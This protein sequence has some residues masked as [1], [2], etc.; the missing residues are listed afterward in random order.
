MELSEFEREMY[1]NAISSMKFIQEQINLSELNVLRD[2][3]VL[4]RVKKQMKE[5]RETERELIEKYSDSPI[6][7]IINAELDER[8]K[9]NEL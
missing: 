6:M 3:V 5:Y 8:V 4:E 2:D 7:N 1:E 9:Q